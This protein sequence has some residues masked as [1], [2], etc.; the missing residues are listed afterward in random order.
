M[1]PFKSFLAAEMEDYLRYRR[2]SLG[3][4]KGPVRS[5]LLTFDDYLRKTE[6][7]RHFFKP[8][9]FLEMRAALTQETRSI[10]AIFSSI[11][12]F[13]HFLAGRGYVDHN[14][15]QDIPRLKKTS[16]CPLFSLPIKSTCC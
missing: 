14:P 1:R 16:L 10:N 3:Y 15:L 6:A 5:H 13:F 2:K 8:D 7:D 9:F 12:G 11:R 4:K